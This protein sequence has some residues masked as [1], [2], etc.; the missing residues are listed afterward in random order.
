MGLLRP[1]QHWRCPSSE[2]KS[3]LRSGA[4]PSRCTIRALFHYWC[5]GRRYNATL[6]TRGAGMRRQAFITHGLWCRGIMRTLRFTPVLLPAVLAWACAQTRD[7][8]AWEIYDA[9]TLQITSFTGMVYC[10]EE[11]LKAHCGSSRSGRACGTQG[12]DVRAYAESL[13]RLIE[14]K[15]ITEAE[16]RRNWARFELLSPAEQSQ[17]SQASVAAASRVAR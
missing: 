5:C 1:R 15:Q 3:C 13:V 11:S 10:G 2:S 9:C 12:N 16:A 17:A 8:A 6:E 7:L 14:A 4:T